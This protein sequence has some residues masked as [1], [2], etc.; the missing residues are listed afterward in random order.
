MKIN[1]LRYSRNNYA[2]QCFPFNFGNNCDCHIQMQIIE[3]ISESQL[4]PVCFDSLLWLIFGAVELVY[5]KPNID[6]LILLY[7]G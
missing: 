1:C 3:G 5:S 4:Y 7:A 6:N 2:C